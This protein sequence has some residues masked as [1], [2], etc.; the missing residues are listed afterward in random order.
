MYPIAFVCII[1]G[2]LVYY[3]GRR[4]LGEARKPWLG[5]DQERGVDGLFTARRKID[6]R[7]PQNGEEEGEHTREERE[8][9]N[10]SPV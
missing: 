1:V 10:T 9:G 3:L 2:Q 7:E 8:R 6:H 5:R 4:V